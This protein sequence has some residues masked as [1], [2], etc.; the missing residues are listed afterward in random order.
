MV[1]SFRFENKIFFFRRSLKKKNHTLYYD[2]RSTTQNIQF[3]SYKSVHSLDRT[4]NRISKVYQRDLE[5]FFQINS[6]LTFLKIYIEIL[7]KYYWYFFGY[8]VHCIYLLLY[9]LHCC[10]YLTVPEIKCYIYPKED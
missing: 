3:V 7:L 6:I 5:I 8:I 9:L 2:Q 10:S 1:V 4:L